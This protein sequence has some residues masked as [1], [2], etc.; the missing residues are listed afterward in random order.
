MIKFPTQHHADVAN[1]V[2][3]YVRRIDGVDTILVVNSCARGQ[4]VVESDLDMAILMSRPINADVLEAEWQAHIPTDTTLKEFCDRSPFSAIHLDFFDGT[5]VAPIWDDGG[6]PDDFE[7][8]IGN[9]VAYSEPLGECGVVFSQLQETW[10][11]YYTTQLSNS[12]LQMAIRACRNDL[13][14]VPFYVSRRLFLQ[15]FDRLYKA[16]R[17]YL[18]ALFIAHQTYP[19]AYNKWLEEQLGWIGRPELFSL[20]LDIL[21]VPK[22]KSADVNFKAATLREMVDGLAES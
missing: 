5:F 4:A 7:I 18:Q 14:F 8:E 6:G 1:K 21:S 13:E 3:E 10:L 17:E 22:L 11:P 12:R 16:F 9:R 20:L 2:T 15:A 19:L